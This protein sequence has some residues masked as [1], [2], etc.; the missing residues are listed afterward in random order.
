MNKFG[1]KSTTIELIIKIY[2]YNSNSSNSN[3][4]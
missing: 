2:D 4:L 3:M 1:I